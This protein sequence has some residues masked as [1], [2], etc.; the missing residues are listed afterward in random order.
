[1]L[2]LAWYIRP[3]RFENS[4]RNRIGRPIRFDIRF[5]RNKKTIRRSLVW[6]ASS[7]AAERRSGSRR[8]EVCDSDSDQTTADA[9]GCG[10]RGTLTE[11]NEGAVAL[12]ILSQLM[13]G[14]TMS[15][16]SSLTLTY[17]DDNARDQSPKYFGTNELR[18]LSFRSPMT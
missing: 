2:R 7:T 12:F 10:S 5:E 3:I 17:M 18:T 15:P 11:F 8:Y 16:T 13:L 1:M 9:G 6:N 4:I 14:M